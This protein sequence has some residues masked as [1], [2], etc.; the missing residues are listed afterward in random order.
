MIIVTLTLVIGVSTKLIKP[1]GEFMKNYAGGYVECLLETGDL[2]PPLNNNPNS[3]CT[4]A[5]MQAAGRF[6][7]SSG[8]S[9]GNGRTSS[10][11]ANNNSNN[12]RNNGGNGNNRNSRGSNSSGPQLQTGSNT[13]A[14]SSSSG[15]SASGSGSNRG[16]KLAA[17]ANNASKKSSNSGGS[18]GSYR[19][20]NDNGRG[21]SGAVKIPNPAALQD[22][23]IKPSASLKKDNKAGGDNLRKGSF[24]APVNK[25]PE[26]DPNAD[27]QADIGFQY[28]M[29]IRY[30]VI[31]GLIIALIIMVGTQLNSLRKS[32]GG[33]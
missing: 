22:K 14:D 3:E 4:V 2:P 25:L 10:N 30:L 17:A 26:R 9:G 8:P 16:D 27:L 19:A 20:L 12:N 33:Q 15:T 1:L 24:S 32:W 23:A 18:E 11:S 6:D 7:K 31:G 5:K 28:G 13:G 21:I 29:Y